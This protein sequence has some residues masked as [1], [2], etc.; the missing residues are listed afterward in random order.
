[1]NSLVALI[2]ALLVAFLGYRIYAQYVDRNVFKADPKKT[3][4]ARMYMDGVD[5]IPANK[6]VL[7]G[8]QFKSI[9]ATG[10]VVG[11]ITALQWGW[12]PAILWLFAGVLF[13]G[14]VQDYS[15]TMLGARQDGQ[16]CTA[17]SYRMISP[18]ARII[19][20]LFMYLYLL[21][22]AGAFGNIIANG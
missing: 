6:N 15:A 20:L 9:A 17:L 11:A 16:T 14:W 8:Y 7:I 21:M 19:L 2:L 1:M 4:P 12:L 3:T 5:F 18:R 10:P 13:I 22:I